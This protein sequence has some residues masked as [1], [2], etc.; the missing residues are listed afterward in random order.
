MMRGSRKGDRE[1]R[2][3][4]GVNAGS[5]FEGYLPERTQKKPN[6]LEQGVS[7]EIGVA[8]RRR[9]GK[10]KGRSKLSNFCTWGGAGSGRP[11]VRCAS[12]EKV[13]NALKGKGGIP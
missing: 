10:R 1:K 11:L 2:N 12:L 13:V 6:L 4:E 9:K 7:A 5:T 3:G 8:S